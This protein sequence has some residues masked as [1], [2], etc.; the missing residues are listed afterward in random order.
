MIKC[1]DESLDA[2]IYTTCIQR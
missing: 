1:D 2:P